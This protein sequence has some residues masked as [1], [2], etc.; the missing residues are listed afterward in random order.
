MAAQSNQS[1]NS[2][3]EESV[4]TPGRLATQKLPKSSR[5]SFEFVRG[6][7]ESAAQKS[8]RGSAGPKYTMNEAA[9]NARP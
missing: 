6:S 2:N 9:R 5:A 1:A 8:A 3:N 4:V 7:N